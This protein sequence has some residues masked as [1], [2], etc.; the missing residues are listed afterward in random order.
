MPTPPPN[1]GHENGHQETE[2]QES[3][4]SASHSRSSEHSDEALLH[5]LGYAQVLYRE[6]GGFSNF[7]ISFTII[8]ILAGCLTSYFIAFQLRRSGRD[9]LG[10]ADRRRLLDPRGDGH[11]RDR[12]GDADGRRAVL[13][14]LQAGRPGLGL[15]HRLVQPGRA[16]RG[17]RGDRLRRRHLHHGA[18]QPVV[19]GPRR[20]RHRD[21]LHRLHGDHRAAHRAEP[22][23]RQPA[24]PAQH[25]LRLVAHG[26]RRRDRRRADRRARSTSRS[27]SS[28]ARRRQLRVQRRRRS[29]TC[30][31]S[32]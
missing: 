9:H 28:S 8:S 27:P 31:S 19:P 25:D 1:D 12:L 4:M 13:L 30:S 3:L 18:A 29:A 17:H 24:G 7:A 10:L 16:D 32:A 26:R 11:G 20:H 2:I 23:Q 21:D 6:M 15:V 14:G 22:A 5:R